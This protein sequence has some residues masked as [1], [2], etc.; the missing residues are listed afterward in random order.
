MIEEDTF[1]PTAVIALRY[2]LVSELRHIDEQVGDL[3]DL[4][5]NYS[6]VRMTLSK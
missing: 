1:L 2:Q 6:V 3:V 4:I 5:D